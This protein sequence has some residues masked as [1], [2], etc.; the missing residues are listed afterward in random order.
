MDFPSDIVNEDRTP[1]YND[2]LKLMKGIAGVVGAEWHLG[3]SLRGLLEEAGFT[4]IS[5]EDVML[6]MG[7]TNNDERLAKEGAASC[8]IAVQGLSKFAKSMCSTSLY[9][10]PH[11]TRATP[12]DITTA[13]NLYS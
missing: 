12:N 1:A 8:G 7:R 13:D 5:E 2:M 6:N 10:T 9:L 4:N 3:R 11:E